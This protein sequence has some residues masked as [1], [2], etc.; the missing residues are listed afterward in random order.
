MS[1]GTLENVQKW[2]VAVA[3]QGQGIQMVD[4]N[5][6]TTIHTEYYRKLIKTNESVKG[7]I[8]TFPQPFE[9]GIIT[10]IRPR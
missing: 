1:S 5:V 3:N 6:D 10:K 8:S 4:K 7:D 2:N 9:I